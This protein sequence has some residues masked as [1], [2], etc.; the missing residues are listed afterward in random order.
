MINTQNLRAIIVNL[1]EQENKLRMAYEE[2]KEQNSHAYKRMLV[3]EKAY[4][5]SDDDEEVAQIFDD[6]Y[7]KYSETEEQVEAIDVA[8]EALHDAT[9]AIG[10]LCL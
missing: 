3:W 2:A 6:V 7:D 8:L 4:T 1:I 10:R 9:K 5:A